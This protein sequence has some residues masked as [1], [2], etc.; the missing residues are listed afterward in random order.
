[1]TRREVWN[2]TVLRPLV[3]QAWE[4]RETGYARDACEAIVETHDR[5]P[6]WLIEFAIEADA[7]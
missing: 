3:I 2:E 5:L 7:A 6:L 4:L 1:M